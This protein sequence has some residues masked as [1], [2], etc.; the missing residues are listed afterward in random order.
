MLRSIQYE[1]QI[2]ERVSKTDGCILPDGLVSKYHLVSSCTVFI[3]LMYEF[4]VA[5]PWK[6]EDCHVCVTRAWFLGL[7]NLCRKLYSFSSC[8]TR[9]RVETRRCHD[10][11]SHS[12]TLCL[13]TYHITTRNIVHHNLQ[14]SQYKNQR[15]IKLSNE[16]STI[17]PHIHKR[18]SAHLKRV[19][20]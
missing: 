18:C 20:V 15:I 3:I 12:H 5:C 14:L 9:V 4:V 11:W 1:I 2:L 8:N 6:D 7:G 17:I 10:Y 13:S 19:I 16:S